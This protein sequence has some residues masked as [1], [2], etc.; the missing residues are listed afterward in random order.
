AAD[1]DGDPLPPGAR[2]RMGTMRFRHSGPVCFVGYAGGGR[3]L[4]TTGYDGYCRVWDVG[5]GR[6]LRRIAL[7]KR[8]SGPVYSANPHRRASG[9]TTNVAL[10]PDGK[11]IAALAD[12]GMLYFWDVASGQ[13]MAEFRITSKPTGSRSMAFA[14][15]GKSLLVCDDHGASLTQWEMSTGKEVRQFGFRPDGA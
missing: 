6:E 5:S 13:R 15:D 11:T 1:V 9:S 2:A 4:V 10:S 12:D 8:K 3:E 7:P 14:A